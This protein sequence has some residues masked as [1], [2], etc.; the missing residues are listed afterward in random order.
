MNQTRLVAPQECWGS[1]IPASWYSLPTTSSLMAYTLNIL[2][3]ATDC[4]VKLTVNKSTE[5]YKEI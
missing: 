5:N 2:Q 4:L 3:F 1:N